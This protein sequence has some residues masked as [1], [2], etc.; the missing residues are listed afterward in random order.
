MERGRS[1]REIAHVS[2]DG[3]SVWLPADSPYAYDVLADHIQSTAHSHGQVGV[4]LKQHQ[5]LVTT[6][7]PCRLRCTC[8][9]P[10]R[11]WMSP[12]TARRFGCTGRRPF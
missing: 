9:T 6:V 10:A 4:S 8:A 1:T 12:A 3:G 11:C 2:W 5:C 7:P